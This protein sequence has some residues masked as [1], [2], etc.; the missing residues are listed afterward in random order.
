MRPASPTDLAFC[1]PAGATGAPLFGA[2]VA[3]TSRD[4]R[5][6]PEPPST[7]GRCNRRKLDT[8]TG[9]ANNGQFLTL[10]A[11]DDLGHP[12]AATHKNGD[13]MKL[14]LFTRFFSS[15]QTQRQIPVEHRN[16][17]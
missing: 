17:A 8:G 7:R 2:S 5:E 13:E 15:P 11:F 14:G 1:T 6:L 16:K 3:Q 4:R 10:A 9:E 12:I